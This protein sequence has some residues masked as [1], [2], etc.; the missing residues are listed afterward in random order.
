MQ[1]LKNVAFD[2]L[3]YKFIQQLEID[4]V[5]KILWANRIRKYLEKNYNFNA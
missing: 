5:P 1:D 2:A 4:N 3:L